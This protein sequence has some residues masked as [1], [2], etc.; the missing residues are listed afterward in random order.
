MFI[1]KHFYIVNLKRMT[2]INNINNTMHLP[3]A[4]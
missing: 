4:D 2:D 3:A 1:R